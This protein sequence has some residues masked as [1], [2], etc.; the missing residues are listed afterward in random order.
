MYILIPY[1]KFNESN[2]LFK[3]KK[4]KDKEFI[5]IMYKMDNMFINDIYLESPNIL[6]VN[7]IKDNNYKIKNKYLLKLICP[8]DYITKIKTIEKSIIDFININI[9]DDKYYTSIIDKDNDNIINI[10]LYKDMYTGITVYD[11][12]NNIYPLESIYKNKAI[13]IILA[14]N[15]IWLNNYNYGLSWRAICIKDL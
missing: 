6:C 14:F 9:T 15:Y 10:T 11:E 8:K 12:N 5:K 4:K 7:S 13:R 1:Y 2:L 3:K